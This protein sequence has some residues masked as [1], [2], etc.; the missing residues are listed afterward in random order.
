M[1]DLDDN[2]LARTTADALRKAAE[3][4]T[5]TIARDEL[6][7]YVGIDPLCARLLGLDDRTGNDITLS[8]S[9]EWESL[10]RAHAA[11]TQT[12]D[13]IV[14]FSKSASEMVLRKTPATYYPMERPT[15]PAAEVSQRSD[16]R[17]AKMSDCPEFASLREDST[18]SDLTKSA[19]YEQRVSVW[20]DALSRGADPFAAL[21]ALSKGEPHVE[22]VR[23]E[24]R[25]FGGDHRHPNDVDHWQSFRDECARA[26]IPA[27]EVQRIIEEAEQEVTSAAA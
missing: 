21:A 12:D 11:L 4:R 17:L 27:D 13:V 25:S 22:H 1:S 2:L 18:S 16:F 7:N 26:G 8:V 6:G 3:R 15:T 19:S 10:R 20:N 5:P 24:P 14:E 9:P 23:R